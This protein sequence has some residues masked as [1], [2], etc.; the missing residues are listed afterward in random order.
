MIDFRGYPR[1]LWIGPAAIAVVGVLPL[2]Y[3]YYQLL[4]LVVCCTFSGLAYAT[5]KA[6]PRMSAWPFILGAA[7]LLFN[8]V[9]PAHLDKATWAVLD[10]LAAALLAVHMTLLRGWAD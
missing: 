2:P 7:A 10:L 6:S 3:G 5:A 4:R 8:P 1:V 9:V